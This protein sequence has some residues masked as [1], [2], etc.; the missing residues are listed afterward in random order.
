M[1]RMDMAFME[2]AELAA[3]TGAAD[4]L[5]QLGMMYCTG[6]EVEADLVYA[7]KWFN[8][9]AIRGSAMARRYRTE[10]AREM[11]ALQV[12]EAQRLAREW[13]STR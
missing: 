8:L 2:K 9:A 4:A 10:I 11:T 5:F 12:A 3:R 1:A 6:H 13:L 7:H